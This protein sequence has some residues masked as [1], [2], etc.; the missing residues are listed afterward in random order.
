MS[1]RMKIEII[2]GFEHTLTLSQQYIVD[3]IKEEKEK[4]HCFL[5]TTMYLFMYTVVH[6]GNGLPLP[7]S[8]SNG[9]EI[10]HKQHRKICKICSKINRP[11]S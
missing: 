10:F 1:K 11:L 3:G 8:L 5:S 7:K 4:G 9:I 6:H 2:P